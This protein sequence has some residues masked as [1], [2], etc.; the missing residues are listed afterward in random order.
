MF[1]SISPTFQATLRAT[2]SNSTSPF[3]Q[4][5]CLE[6]QN[7]KML[8]DLYVDNRLAFDSLLIWEGSAVLNGPLQTNPHPRVTKAY[9][10]TWGI[11]WRCWLMSG[12]LAGMLHLLMSA[13]IKSTVECE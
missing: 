6:K 7:N 13:L 9:T 3:K 1:A 11:E 4:K 2:F 12:G 5:V 10:A 8:V